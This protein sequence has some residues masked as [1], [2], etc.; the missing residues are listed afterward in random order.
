MNLPSIRDAKPREVK[1][2]FFDNQLT[3]LWNLY[4]KDTGKMLVHTGALGWV[5]SSAAQIYAISSDKTID[6]EKKKFLL[7]QEAADMAVN[8]G[9]YYS[10]CT[11]IKSGA[12]RLID[13]G[14]LVSGE[15]VKR[16]M[17]LPAPY[18]PVSE[19]KWSDIFL[20][21]ELKNLSETFENVENIELSK[22]SKRFDIKSVENILKDAASEFST[23]KNGV[24]CVA[25]IFASV[26]ACN[27]I[28]PFAR[29]AVALRVK[30]HMAKKDA[31]KDN[32]NP[33]PRKTPYSPQRLS[34]SNTPRASF[35]RAVPREYKPFYTN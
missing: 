15:F 25:A 28:T 3:G 32:V 20:K 6:K 30:D 34:F 8:V 24:G 19:K 7:P 4:S 9:L 16:L 17:E 22:L 33:A 23:F 13:K 1:K 31:I 26:L 29:N 11:L 10:V 2:W 12:D 35:N 21:K 5:L 18:K 27:V 14:K